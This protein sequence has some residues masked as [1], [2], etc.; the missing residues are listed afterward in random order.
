MRIDFTIIFIMNKE[1]L[2]HRNGGLV[3]R[4]MVV[5]CMDTTHAF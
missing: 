3:V 4:A 2:I 1:Y 5:R